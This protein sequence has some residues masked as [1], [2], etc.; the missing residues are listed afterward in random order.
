MASTRDMAD[1]LCDQLRDAGEIRCKKMFGE[2]GLYCDGI[3]FGCICDNQLFIKPTATNV[4]LLEHPEPAAP[5]E[6]AKPCWRTGRGCAPWCGAPVRNCRGKN[7]G[8]PE[9]RNLPWTEANSWLWWIIRK[10]L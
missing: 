5:Y 6:G 2:F 8:K 1:Y 3:Y 9:R 7:R 10:I 4:E